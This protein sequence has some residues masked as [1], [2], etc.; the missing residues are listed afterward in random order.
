[1]SREELLKDL[2]YVRSMAEA[3]REAPLVGGRILALWGGLT[4]AALAAQWASLTE[5]IAPPL[6]SDLWIWVAQFVVGGAGMFL[7]L[8]TM[9]ETPGVS[10]ANNRVAAAVWS[11]F[12]ITFLPVLAAV[13]CAQLF[14]DAPGYTA[15]LIAAI[16]LILYGMAHLTV[17][18]FMRRRDGRIAGL[19]SIAFGAGAMA[20]YTTFD[21][22]LVS[23]AGLVFGA[24]IPGLLQWMR[25]P[26]ATV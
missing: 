14:F 15:N 20:M 21:A 5:R 13:V 10:A 7:I 25:E 8:R 26:K 23:A 9:G 19:I 3:G 24:F 6:G 4:A 11:T 1:M 12:P 17:A 22:M 16:A 18:A 2:D